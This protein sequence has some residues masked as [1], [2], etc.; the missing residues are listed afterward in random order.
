MRVFL[1][2]ASTSVFRCILPVISEPLEFHEVHADNVEISAD[3]R[4]AR[5]TD[6]QRGLCFSQRPILQNE[7][8]CIRISES[9]GGRSHKG[10]SMRFGFTA[11]DPATDNR[12]TSSDAMIAGHGYWVKPVS[13]SVAK[14]GSAVFFFLNESGEVIHGRKDKDYG[15]LFSGVR[16][17]APLWVV[18]DLAGSAS[19][20]EFLGES[21][22]CVSFCVAVN[23]F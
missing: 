19:S 6:G 1:R 2:F 20:I 8:V 23:C 10:I 16:T 22:C 3:H 17:G 14:R 7:V 12:N 15:V 13:D 18:I 4:R 9:S 5:R 11:V 21:I